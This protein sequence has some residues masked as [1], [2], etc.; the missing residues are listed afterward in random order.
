MRLVLD[1]HLSK[2]KNLKIEEGCLVFLNLGWGKKLLHK[3]P[4][5]DSF[6]QNLIFIEQLHFWSTYEIAITCTQT[7]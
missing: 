6:F 4:N 5:S 2:I 3:K 1:M 7:L